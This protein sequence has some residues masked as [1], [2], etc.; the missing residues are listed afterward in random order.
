MKPLIVMAVVTATGL[1]N[2]A[3]AGQKHDPQYQTPVASVSQANDPELAHPVAKLTGSPHAKADLSVAY[4]AA[5]A[6]SKSDLD[7]VHNVYYQNGSPHAKAD[8]YVA[9]A[10]STEA[11]RAAVYGQQKPAEKNFQVA[12]L[13]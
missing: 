9:F 1:A 10:A 4:A 11:D 5:G 13:K 2:V 8:M 7:I 3:V 12:P 6:S